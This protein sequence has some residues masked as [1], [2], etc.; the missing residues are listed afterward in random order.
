MAPANFVR[1]QVT[2][3][4]IIKAVESIQDHTFFVLREK[5]GFGAF[6]SLAEM[7]ETLREEFEECIEASRSG[8]AERT[9]QELLDVA[10]VCT[11]AIACISSGKFGKIS[12]IHL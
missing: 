2:K 5:H 8:D 10:Q 9:E 12:A 6:I 11:F 7:V 1:S 4:E 3:N